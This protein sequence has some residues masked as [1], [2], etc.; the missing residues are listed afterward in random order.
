M[1]RRN[2]RL[3]VLDKRGYTIIFVCVLVE[4]LYT[5]L[6]TGQICFY[7]ADIVTYFDASI[8]TMSWQLDESRPPVYPFMLGVLMA[9]VHDREVV[10]LIMVAIQW[11]VFLIS[12]V[13]LGRLLGRFV[14]SE[15][16]AFWIVLFYAV[17]PGINSL[18]HVAMTDSLGLSFTVFYLYLCMRNMNKLTIKSLF[19]L[20]GMVILMVMLRPIF[21][22]LIPC[23]ILFNCVVWFTKG[24]MKRY[25]LGS[26]ACVVLCAMIIGGYVY[27]MNERYG[28]RTIALTSATNNYHVV[29]M[30]HAFPNGDFGNPELIAAVDS[31][32]KANPNI[33]ITDFFN[34]WV[35][36]HVRFG[37][38]E[39]SRFVNQTMSDNLTAVIPKMLGHFYKASTCQLFCSA[40]PSTLWD[41]VAV[42]FA[43]YYIVAIM[44]TCLIV[45]QYMKCRE[46]KP[47]FMVSLAIYVCGLIV[48]IAGAPSE[49][50]RI[51]LPCA[52]PMLIFIGWTFDHLKIE[53][54]G[55]MS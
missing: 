14:K 29:R 37:G 25:I 38:D 44:W 35:D 42:N 22:Y 11:I 27:G 13:Y 36:F 26:L 24:R 18:N 31:A 28:I 34:E 47:L 41:L 15:S 51:T 10:E 20:W 9:L 5:W 48:G 43:V 17:C 33:G 6:F 2:N 45:F 19:A 52:V 7:H 46:I 39:M 8:K 1:S 4:I 21:V 53:K 50:G 12:A 32:Y 16:I 3:F 23:T 30:L 55:V 49:F 54:I 40:V